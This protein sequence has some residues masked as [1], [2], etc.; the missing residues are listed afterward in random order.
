MRAGRGPR[1]RFH[2]HI[3][4]TFS[5]LSKMSSSFFPSLPP[6]DAWVHAN[7]SILRSMRTQRTD[8]AA[9]AHYQ[10]C[11]GSHMRQRSRT[12]RRE[13]ARFHPP[14]DT[15]YYGDAWLVLTKSFIMLWVYYLLSVD[16]LGPPPRD[17]SATMI[18]AL[19][20]FVCA[21]KCW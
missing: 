19:H 11:L 21:G 20:L 7:L 16:K 2:F 9:T 15:R 18:T 6:S 13:S 10:M 8:I 1:H 14:Q 5:M 4:T 12:S 17:A 3:F